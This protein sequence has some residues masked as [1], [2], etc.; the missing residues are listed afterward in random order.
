M[1][2]VKFVSSNK[3]LGYVVVQF[4]EI[5]KRLENK[6][7]IC[8]GISIENVKFVDCTARKHGKFDVGD[9]RFLVRAD[10]EL[11]A[12]RL[13]K[14]QSQDLK[15]LIKT[16]DGH[17]KK[18]SAA[19][20]IKRLQRHKEKSH[21]NSKLPVLTFPEEHTG[22]KRRKRDW[23]I[24]PIH[25]SEND[26][27]PFPKKLVQIKSNKVTKIYY[28]ITG[29]GADTPPEGVFIIEKETGW[30]LVTQPLDREKLSTYVLKSHAVSANGQSVEEPMDIIIEV[31]DQNDNRP[32]FTEQVFRGSVKEGVP[33]GT[34]VMNV[35]ATDDDDPQT[36]NAILGYS[37]L[38]QEPED[39]SAGLFTINSETGVISVIGT[40]L[41]REK[42]P[43]YT[44]TVQVADMEGTGLSSTAK[45]VIKVL[46]ANDNAPIFD[47]LT[48]Q[49][50][51]PEN[52]VGFEVKRLSVTDDDE[53]YS[54]AWRAVYKIKGNEGG[55]FSIAT[56]K[57]TNEGILTTAKGLDFETRKQFVLQITVENEERFSVTLP[58]STATV[59]VN[60]ED[61]NEAPFFVPQVSLAEVSEDLQRGQ[62]ITALVA[63]DPDKQQNQKLR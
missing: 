30:L 54:P 46:D 49:A 15:F 39:P 3:F 62:K 24:P 14:L 18:Y 12:K 7:P 9:A 47:P 22:L 13:V 61:V 17:G 10:G 56:D 53:M 36:A 8:F 33:P 16:W 52:E 25:L 60:V 51:V 32:V 23:V 43:E 28:S 21:R 59:T 20:V 40:G 6:G 26:R 42:I 57:D 63:Q 37:I 1:N 2:E 55:F 29:Q 50:L 38:K 41:D 11:I 34:P 58:T 48:Y 19:V 5:R 35:T 31:I 45:A 27:G 4:A 44:L